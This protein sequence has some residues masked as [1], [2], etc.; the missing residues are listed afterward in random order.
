MK[1]KITLILFMA[2]SIIGLSSCSKETIDSITRDTALNIITAGVWQKATKTISGNSDNTLNITTELLAENQTLNFDK[3]GKAWI[4][5]TESDVQTSKN[6][7]LS[8]PKKMT[9]DGMDYD[10]KE[11]IVQS[12]A[13]LTLINI[14]ASVRTEIVFKRK[15]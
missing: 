10:I 7:N 11:N 5:T 9:F 4:K 1:T 8:S 13:T 12:I 6:Y 14:T 3:D 2:V 15:R